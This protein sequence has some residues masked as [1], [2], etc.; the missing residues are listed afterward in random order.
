[1]SS[2]H[3][4]GHRNSL[5]IS[6]KVQYLI[7]YFIH[8]TY[9]IHWQLNPP[10]L[11]EKYNNSTLCVWCTLLLLFWGVYWTIIGKTQI[12]HFNNKPAHWIKQHEEN[13]MTEF[14][15]WRELLTLCQISEADMNVLRDCVQCFSFSDRHTHTSIRVQ[16]HF[17]T[18]TLHYNHQSCTEQNLRNELTETPLFPIVLIHHSIWCCT[19]LTKLI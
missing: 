4:T 17:I 8:A 13:I 6:Y 7:E 1:M 16:C 5:S 11:L 9:S 15:F 3:I 18:H 10:K 12:C 2:F 19:F 14:S